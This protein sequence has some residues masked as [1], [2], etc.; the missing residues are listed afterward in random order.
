M[1]YMEQ[2]DFQNPDIFQILSNIIGY[3]AIILFYSLAL[4]FILNKLFNKNGNHIQKINFISSFTPQFLII[5]LY[6]TGK[7]FS[8][9]SPSNNLVS[10]STLMGYILMSIF[11]IF[12]LY[13]CFDLFDKLTKIALKKRLLYVSIFLILTIV[14]FPREYFKENMTSSIKD[15]DSKQTSCL[16]I[17]KICQCFGF[18]VS[19]KM[20]LGPIYSCETSQKIIDN[21]FSCSID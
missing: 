12:P 15:I 16:L 4:R 9:L 7:S 10:S 3:F 8:F 18:K 1:E 2:L 13:I 6:I 11:F 5:L 20:C 21:Q 14:F 17:T 19:T